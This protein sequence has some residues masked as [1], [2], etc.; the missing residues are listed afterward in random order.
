[1]SGTNGFPVCPV[2][3][4][5]HT[6]AAHTKPGWSHTCRAAR[7]EAGTGR[8]RE[9]SCG[10]L[11]HTGVRIRAVWGMSFV[12]A[13]TKREQL[14][15]K[16]LML[17]IHWLLCSPN[18]IFCVADQCETGLIN[19]EYIG[20]CQ[21]RATLILTLLVLSNGAIGFLSFPGNNFHAESQSSR[22]QVEIN[23]T[24][25]TEAITLPVTVQ[26]CMKKREMIEIL[27]FTCCRFSTDGHIFWPK[28]RTYSD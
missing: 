24:Y 5:F 23:H 3:S 10:L 16:T 9:G 15:D 17:L 11:D 12:T 1:M 28:I 22:Y 25:D 21:K 20:L 2:Q 27:W 14:Q 7:M 4:S 13:S 26:K 6:L 18:L 19:V 8:E